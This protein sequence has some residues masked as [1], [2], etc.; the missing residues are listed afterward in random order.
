MVKAEAND[1][2]LL[3][4]ALKAGQYYASQGPEIVSVTRDGDTLLV[5][6]SPAQS[7]LVAGHGARAQAR[8]GESL[9][10]AEFDLAAF[11][12]SWLRLVVT[13]TQGKRAWGQPLFIAS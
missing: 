5:R 13:D 11:A 3:L 2:D 10:E 4:A 9:V 8:H 7:I 1:P 6:T 12:G